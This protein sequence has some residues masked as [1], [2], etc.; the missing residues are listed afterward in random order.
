MSSSCEDKRSGLRRKF[1]PLFQFGRALISYR[2]RRGRA[3]SLARRSDRARRRAEA[4]SK[5]RGIA[6]AANDGKTE[7]EG[8]EKRGRLVMSER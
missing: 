7:G 2:K 1:R 6:G 3:S 5:R 8:K 4:A